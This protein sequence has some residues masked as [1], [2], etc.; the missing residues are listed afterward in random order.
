MKSKWDWE[1]MTDRRASHETGIC[2]RLSER[3]TE[4][5]T[6]VAICETDAGSGF[7]KVFM[8]RETHPSGVY[9]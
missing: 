5:W 9:L 2:E 8:R 4:G 3:E 7:Y 6:I 1:I